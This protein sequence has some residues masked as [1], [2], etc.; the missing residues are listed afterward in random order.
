MANET[1]NSNGAY[2]T[3][4]GSAAVAGSAFSTA[5]NATNIGTAIP[6][7]SLYPTL[8]FQLT[9]SAGTVTAGDVINLYR[10]SHDGITQA[11]IPANTSNDAKQTYVGSFI[12]VSNSETRYL[13]SVRNL[14]ADDEYYIEN[15]GL[16]SITMTVKVR[17][18]TYGPA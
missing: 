16:A 17:G 8:D 18:S 4:I 12:L 14:H 10:R 11:P 9:T 2:T 5:G 13:D 6:V 3:C 7:E 15:T 1:L